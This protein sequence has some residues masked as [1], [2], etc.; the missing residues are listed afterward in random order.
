MRHFV[1]PFANYCV[2]SP[3]AHGGATVAQGIGYRQQYEWNL[4]SA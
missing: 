2:D 4:R 3:L 1:L